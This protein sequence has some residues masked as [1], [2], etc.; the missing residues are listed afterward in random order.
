ME[1]HGMKPQVVLT[2]PI[3]VGTD[4]V[5]RMSKSTG[6]Y[7]GI[8]ESP[9][10]IFTKVLNLPDH[11]MRNYA[12]LVT[13]WRQQEIDAW[14]AQTET[15]TLPMRDFKHKLAREIVSIFHGDEAADRAAE[16]ASRMHQ[17]EAPSD[18]PVF[19]L[20]GAKTIVDILSEAGLVKSRGEA[21]RLIDQGGVRINGNAITNIEHIV[22]ANPNGETVIQAG[23]RKFLRV[24]GE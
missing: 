9:G 20:Q 4:G 14:L 23:K 19:T 6:N 8:N 16:D 7:I 18:A 3:L 1:A 2:F 15:G 24:K 17:G 11:V 13:R 22:A 21:R 12:E 10:V 5:L